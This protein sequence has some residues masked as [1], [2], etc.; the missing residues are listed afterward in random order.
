MYNYEK[1]DGIFLILF[2]F[3]DL[4]LFICP[5]VDIKWWQLVGMMIFLYLGSILITHENKDKGDK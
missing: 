3:F 5:P 2:V 1:G 4:I